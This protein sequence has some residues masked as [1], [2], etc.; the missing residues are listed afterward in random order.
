MTLSAD[1]WFAG[2]V[3]IVATMHR[4]EQVIAPALTT[5][6]GLVC[7]VPPDFDTDRFG[8]FTRDVD[9]PGDQ[10]ATAR[11]KAE[12]ALDLTGATVA[13][14]SEGSFGPHPQ[15]P[16][17]PCNRELVL[18][19]DRDHGLEIVGESLSTDTNYR[20]QAVATP[21]EALTF[22]KTVGFPSH[23]LVAMAQ[24]QGG[25]PDTI[26]KGITDPAALVTAVET[27]TRRSPTGTV[28]LETDMRAMYNPT[29]MQAI[30]AATA[31]LVATA[32]RLCPAC[33][34]PGFALV[35][36]HP[37][38]PC[39]DCGTPTLLTQTLVYRCDRCH[40]QQAQP[41]PEAP[42]GADPTYCPYCNP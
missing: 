1:G 32:Q 24:P 22:A 17:L 5:G 33:G 9:R 37:G 34:V 40:H 39:G 27:L 41:D 20:A 11:R 18:L 10:R 30:A 4:K 15:I 29:R 26:L 8:T 25:P 13:I 36:R 35:A 38:L 21:A 16:W 28:H 42:A 31:D 12:A 23:G 6:L 14:A 7:Q 3:A 19:L 2:R